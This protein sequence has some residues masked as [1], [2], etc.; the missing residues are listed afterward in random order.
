MICLTG[1][2]TADDGEHERQARER[3]SGSSG[4][5]TTATTPP[6]DGAYA[7]WFNSL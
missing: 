5:E 6:D 1:G 3:D 7:N 4:S 2:F